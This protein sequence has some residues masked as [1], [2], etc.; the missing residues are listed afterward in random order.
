MAEKQFVLVSTL[1]CSNGEFVVSFDTCE[2][3]EK[4]AVDYLRAMRPSEIR[5]I[6][7]DRRY[8]LTYSEI[9]RQ[10]REEFLGL[11]EWFFVKKLT[12]PAAIRTCSEHGGMI[13]EMRRNEP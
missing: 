3:A 8:C 12:S 2:E 9:L 6:T 11:S 10:Y 13:S 7:E 4:F 5:Q 1:D